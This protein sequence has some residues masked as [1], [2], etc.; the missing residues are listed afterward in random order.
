M[1]EFR[2]QCL[3]LIRQVESGG[4]VVEIT[5]HGK[6]VARLMPPSLGSGPGPKPWA[7]LR[8]SGVLHAE[9]EESV[10][11]AQAFDALR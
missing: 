7:A 9:P 10:L 4:E 11:D 1:T 6:L 5:R 3:E 2:A 8:G